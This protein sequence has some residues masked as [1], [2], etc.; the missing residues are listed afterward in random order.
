MFLNHLRFAFR[1]L[2][3]QKMHSLVILLG[4]SV[5]MASAFLVYSY[6]YFE[7]SYDDFHHKNNLYRVVVDAQKKG[8]DA[9]KSPYSYSAQGPTALYEVPEVKSFTRLIPMSSIVISRSDDSDNDK[10]FTI[11]NFYYADENFFETFSFPLILGNANNVLT[12]NG[13]MVITKKL[14]GKLFGTE[15][16]VGK[17]LLIDGKYTNTITGV[18]DDIP[19]NTH[20]KFDI[21]FSLNT[22]PWILDPKNQWSNQSFFTYLV[23][24]VGA[25][26]SIAEAKIT[27]AYAKEER[28]VNQTDCVWELQPIDESY[29][30]TEDFTSKPGAFKFGDLQM[31]YFLSVMTILILSVAWAN[32]I[33]LTTAKNSERFDEIEIRKVNGAGKS[34]LLIQFFTESTLLT[35]TSL[36]LA[37][38]V[39]VLT[40]RKFT[41]FMAFPVNVVSQSSFWIIPVFVILLSVF[42][43][44][45]YT[46]FILSR[47]YDVS[48]QKPLS[49][50]NLRNAMVILQFI[51]IIGLLASVF[52]INRQLNHINKMDLGFQKDQILVLNMPRISN[53]NINIKNIET[54]RTEL[55]KFTGIVDVSA[56]TSIPGERFGS[57]NGSPKIYGQPSEDTYFR[58]GR[59]MNNYPEL[60]NFKFIAG[61]SFG[62]SDN[63]MIVNKAAVEEFGFSTPIEILNKKVNWQGNEFIIAGVTENFHQESLHILPEPMIMYTKQIEN[64]FNFLLVRLNGKDLKNTMGN[65]ED[66]FKAEF[67]GNPFTFFFLDKYFDQ[68]YQ[69][70]I[71]FRQLFSFFSII[72]LIIG[73]FGLY[74]LTTF[75]I[76]RR[77]KEIGIRKVN[78]ANVSEILTMLN[79]NFIRVVIVAFIVATPVAYFAMNKWLENFAYKTELSWWIFALAGLLALGIALLTV[80]W[81]SWKAASRNPVEALRYE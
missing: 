40:F 69:K 78:G 61:N 51:I 14:A 34:H 60:M 57:G 50:Y 41:G 39:V 5:S 31:I 70:D 38:F 16:P 17:S 23:L 80:S 76:I 44:G 42:I 28:A 29:L 25:D 79:G 26:P 72:T 73:F 37:V 9:Y 63:K 10:A 49:K 33:N 68:Q 77:I 48:I 32:Y 52:V 71:R 15:N 43:P 3:S 46:A 58:V 18:M 1:N 45:L 81:Q 13:S 53:Q 75:T 54:F 8:E 62:D 27:K 64:D 65:I 7:K 19:E 35:L 47:K 2:K 66:E 11:N 56:T 55:D 21:I 20:L 6:V 36:M 12:K 24:N 67:S 4:L 74:G 22:I 59:V 30:N